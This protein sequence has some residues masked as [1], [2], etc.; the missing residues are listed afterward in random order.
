MRGSILELKDL[1][2]ELYAGGILVKVMELVGARIPGH[3]SSGLFVRVS[4]A[5]GGTTANK[6]S[7]SQE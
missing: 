3:G 5:R 7:W 6:K 2:A 1:C 4:Y